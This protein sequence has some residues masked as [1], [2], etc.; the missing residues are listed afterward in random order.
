MYSKLS[1]LKVSNFLYRF[2][3]SNIMLQR[4]AV[5]FHSNYGSSNGR[6]FSQFCQKFCYL[7]LLCQN[8]DP[9]RMSGSS[10]TYFFNSSYNINPSNKVTRRFKNMHFF[11]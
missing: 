11:C 10:E 7:F 8:N 4:Q 6:C 2:T 5:T 1:L 9:E 3:F